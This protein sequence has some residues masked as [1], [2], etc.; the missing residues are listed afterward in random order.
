M[1]VAVSN[2]NQTMYSKLE[3]GLTWSVP[4]T[5]AGDWRS[6]VYG[7]NMFV[8]VANGY[9]SYSYDGI[10][11]ISSTLNETGWVLLTAIMCL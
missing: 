10:T 7:N 1:Y 5:L 4:S 3:H 2:T 9:T 6:V 11:W 8:A